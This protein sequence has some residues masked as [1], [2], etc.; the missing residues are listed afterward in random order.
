MKKAIRQIAL[1][2]QTRLKNILFPLEEEFYVYI[3]REG[4]YKKVKKKDL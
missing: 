3:L 2:I 4:R 1:A